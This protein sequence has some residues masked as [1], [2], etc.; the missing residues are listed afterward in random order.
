MSFENLDDDSDRPRRQRAP[1]EK[2][3]S[4]ITQA[5]GCLFLLALG[6]LC[7]GVLPRK[8]ISP[9]AKREPVG[10]ATAEMA[11]IAFVATKTEGDRDVMDLYAVSGHFDL[12]KL[13]NFCRNRKESSTAK[14]FYYLV[15]FD[16]KANARFPTTPFTAEFGIEEDALRHIRAIY[17]FNRLNGFSELRHYERNMWESTPRLEKL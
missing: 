3:P 4:A 16:D 11:G 1:K 2:K 13:K 7:V 8:P 17:V 5:V 9:D 10:P 12:D 14:V 15:V 6:A